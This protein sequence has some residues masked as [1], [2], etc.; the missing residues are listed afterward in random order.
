MENPYI[1]VLVATASKQEAEKIAQNLLK[2][3]LIACAN[4]FGPVTSHFH[5]SG[6]IECSEEFLM[7][8]KS[9]M[10]L[11][12]R[13]SEAVCEMHSYKVPEILALPVVAGIKP[14]LDWM[15]DFLK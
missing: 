13:L 8:L 15:N 5:W 7:I 4:I 3:K 1:I 2:E 14:Y 9:R 12:K 6:K 11:F 10:D